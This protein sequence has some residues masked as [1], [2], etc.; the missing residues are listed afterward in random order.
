MKK[1]I[2]LLIL[3]IPVHTASAKCAAEFF[4]FSGIV[5]NK[6]GAPVSGALVGISWSEREGPAGPA[7]AV[8]NRKGYYKI[9]VLF[10]TYSGKGKIVEDECEQRIGA[11]SVSA[12]K[13]ELRSSYQKVPVSRVGNIGLPAAVIWLHAD[14]KPTVRL[15]SPSS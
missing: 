6:A 8:T 13:G 15:I 5:T 9:P 12:S 3:L 11:V 2:A 7:L 1:L 10:S 14:I 4:V